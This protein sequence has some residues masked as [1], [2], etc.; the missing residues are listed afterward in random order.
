MSGEKKMEDKKNKGWFKEYL[1]DVWLAGA[2]TKGVEAG[3]VEKLYDEMAE[4]SAHFWMIVTNVLEWLWY[5]FLGAG[6]LVMGAVL[7]ANPVLCIIDGQYEILMHGIIFV[8]IPIIAIV[9]WAY[10]DIFIL[11]KY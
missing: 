5:G 9:V 3:D 4:R 10:R 7:I 6:F 1:K 11:K 2:R 8:Y